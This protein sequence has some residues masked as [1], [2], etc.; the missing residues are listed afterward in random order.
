MAAIVIM[1]AIAAINI[2]K[3][4]QAWTSSDHLG[5]LRDMTNIFKESMPE[6]KTKLIEPMLKLSEV[7]VG[8]DGDITS[9]M[10]SILQPALNEMKWHL[11]KEVAGFKELMRSEVATTR[12]QIQREIDDI[13][14]SLPKGLLAGVLG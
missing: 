1:V 5:H 12:E 11:S 9:N 13:K 2:V 10:L 7:L 4:T 3:M 8:G 14:R 6:M